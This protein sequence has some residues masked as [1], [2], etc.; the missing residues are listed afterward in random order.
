[1]YIAPAL[2]QYLDTIFKGGGWNQKPQ[3]LRGIYFSNSFQKGSPLDPFMA[4]AMGVPV[5]ELRERTVEEVK[6]PM[7]LRDLFVEKAFREFGLVTN[8]QNVNSRRRKQKIVALTG[9]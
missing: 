1:M 3:F 7:F 6:K 2:R 8:E 4:N 9:G 5:S